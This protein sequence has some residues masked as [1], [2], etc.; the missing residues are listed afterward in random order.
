MAP[1]FENF[2]SSNDQSFNSELRFEKNLKT[3]L[4]KNLNT[5]FIKDLSPMQQ[6]Y[7]KKSVFMT[8]ATGF[9]GKGKD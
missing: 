7:Y 3:K 5:F 1:L 2:M 9:L 8:G 6:F 4:K